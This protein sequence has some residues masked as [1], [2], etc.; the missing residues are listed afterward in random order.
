MRYILK[1]ESCDRREAEKKLY[2][3]IAGS[4]VCPWLTHHLNTFGILC[5]DI[6]ILMQLLQSKNISYKYLSIY[7][8]C[9][10]KSCKCF[11]V[12]N[13]YLSI[14]NNCLSQS[15]KCFNVINF[16]L[17]VYNNCL[18]KSCKCFNM[19]NKS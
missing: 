13:F 19:T 16:Y 8:N 5:V 7:S 10:S 4:A 12:I 14:Y 15:C 17:S 6:A 1:A 11:N 3:I 9:L 2:C 18:S